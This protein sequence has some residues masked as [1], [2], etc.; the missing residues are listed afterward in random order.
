[1]PSVVI[2]PV[3]LHPLVRSIAFNANVFASFADACITPASNIAIKTPQIRFIVHLPQ[4]TR[5][6]CALLA[7]DKRTQLRLRIGEVA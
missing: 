3:T 2:V 6:P 4:E 5:A 1:V 7:E